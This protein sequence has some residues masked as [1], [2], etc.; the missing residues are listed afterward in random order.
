LTQY[1]SFILLS[2]C[3]TFT[4]VGKCDAGSESLPRSQY[5]ITVQLDTATH[6]LTAE[7]TLT[8][9]NPDTKPVD[10]MLFHMYYNA[11]KNSNSTFLT[12]SEFPDF[13]SPTSKDECH[14]A[15]T[16]V[17]NIRDQSGNNLTK[18]TSYIQPD[19]ANTE[20]QTVLRLDL[21]KPLAPGQSVE[22]KF[23][24][25]A[26]IPHI[27]PRTGY[28]QEYY[29]LAQWF[30][31]LGVYE[32]PG[33]RYATEGGWNCHQYH[34][35]GE[36]YSEFA[37]Y[38]VTMQVPS[39]YIVASS[40]QLVDKQPLDSN[41]TSWTYQVDNVIDFTWSASPHFVKQSTAYRDTDIHFYTYPY[42][43]E[44]APRYFAAIE[45]CMDYLDSHLGPY[46]YPT[47]SIIDPPIHGMFTGG[48]E[49][50]TL[51]SSLSF[52]FLPDGLRTPETLVMH[53][54][55]HQYFMQMVATHE[56]EEP[57]M[58]EGFTTYWEGRILDNYLGQSS[59]MIDYLGFHV[60]TKEY[61]R[62]EFLR[63]PLNQSGANTLKSYEYEP[64]AYGPI[65]YNKTA[66]WLQTLERMLGTALMDEIWRAYFLEWQYR[67]PCRQD[68]IDIVNDHV[69]QHSPRFPQ[70]MD[71]YFDQVI[72]GTALCD[73]SITQISNSETQS[74]TGYLDSTEDCQVNGVIPDQTTY[75]SRVTIQRLEEMILPITIRVTF[76]DGTTQYDTLT[77]S[78]VVVNLDYLGGSQII[79]AAVDPDTINYLDSNLINNT[80][81]L[82]PINNGTERSLKYYLQSK[83]QHILEF[84]SLLI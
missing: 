66:L 25:S 56:V 32:V 78:D 50:P 67:H 43:Q 24:W 75:Q 64:S 12:E 13:L 46:P 80:Y 27:M 19:N 60:G 9:T 1:L 76:E 83:V 11:F 49:Y 7:T 81:S 33:M 41:T 48:M 28:N 17:D 58:D 39:D 44:I 8:W 51:I 53:E 84:L 45:Y 35:N 6:T 71:W 38:T 26:K 77:G 47:L 74:P 16:Q 30:P 10:H 72:Y 34:A 21:D 42:K 62:S 65:S 61:N 36:Y 3:L 68:F 23:N 20:D 57:W 79:S 15:Y 54:F 63:D 14:W 59:S 55:I 40:G 37:D 31:K 4:L 82:E 18:N 5:S 69:I 70:G 2:F 29:F 52:T 22:L 73:Y